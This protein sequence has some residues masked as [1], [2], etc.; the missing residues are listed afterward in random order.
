[1]LIRLDLPTFD[2]PITANSGCLPS[3]G[4]PGRSTALL[5]KAAVL[6]RENS[7]GGSR[8][9]RGPSSADAKR[10]SAST[11]AAACLLLG[12]GRFLAALPAAADGAGFDGEGAAAGLLLLGLLL[13]AAARHVDAASAAAAL[14][15]PSGGRRGASAGAE[16]AGCR[17]QRDE[18]EVP[19]CDALRCNNCR[20]AAIFSDARTVQHCSSFAAKMICVGAQSDGW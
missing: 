7:P 8:S 20:D 18:Q 12:G 4:Q 3:G 17:L 2:R 11:F 15:Q 10:P 9:P 16:L 6:M 13:L 5:M 1:M 14:R 19:I